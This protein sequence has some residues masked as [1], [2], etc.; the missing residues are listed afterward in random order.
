MTTET[1]P[2]MTVEH[3][4]FTIERT[5][6]FDR[7]TVF[8][9]WATETAK[10]GW[11]GEELEFLSKLT[12]YELDFRVG[13]KEVLEGK[14]ASG[15]AFALDAI[16]HDIVDERRIVNAYDVRID[17]RL[18]SSSLLTVE[19]RDAT[20]GCTLVVTEQG[21]FLDGFD[22]NA[23]RTQGAAAE[24]DRLGRYLAS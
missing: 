12:R 13:G 18:I 17:D 2:A 23:E 15:R 10:R 4:T 1:A 3:G 14:L 16:Y 22:T 24:L 21:A 19:F 8:A 9:A 20:G 5:Y 7:A 6:P 11:Y